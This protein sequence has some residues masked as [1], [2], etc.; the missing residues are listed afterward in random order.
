MQILRKGSEGQDV[1][2]WQEFMRGRNLLTGVDGVFGPL[3]EAAT[4]RFNARSG[5]GPTAWSAR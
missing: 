5:S 1:R 3:T 4:K 2:R